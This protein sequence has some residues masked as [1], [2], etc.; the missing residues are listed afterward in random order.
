MAVMLKRT[1][2]QPFYPTVKKRL[3]T[4]LDLIKNCLR[5]IIE[6]HVEKR[7]ATR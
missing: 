2:A 4:R 7:G 3:P 1:A 6:P 5:E